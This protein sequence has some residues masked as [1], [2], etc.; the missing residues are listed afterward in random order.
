MIEAGEDVVL[1]L[2]VWFSTPPKGLVPGRTC[3]YL[4]RTGEG[5]W[6]LWLE[7]E[8]GAELHDCFSLHVEH[9]KYG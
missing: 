5:W 9:K 7:V 1:S 3:P 8:G 2:E 6:P 4:P